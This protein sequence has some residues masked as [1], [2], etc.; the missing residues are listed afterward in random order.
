MGLIKE[1]VLLPVAPVRGV[2][3]VAE[4]ISEQA[5][6]ELY[7]ESAGVQRLDDLEQKRERGELG[8]EEAKRLE[9]EVIQRQLATASDGGMQEG[10]GRG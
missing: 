4:R 10:A 7:S 2:M 8:E 5:E 1:L 6:R 9:E 3:W